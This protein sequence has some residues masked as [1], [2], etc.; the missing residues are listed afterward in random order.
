MGI[1]ICLLVTAGC[2]SESKSTVEV[3]EISK[4]RV[5]IFSYQTNGEQMVLEGNL[6]IDG[7]EFPVELYYDS[8]QALLVRNPGDTEQCLAFGP[9]KPLF[10]I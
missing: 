4:N 10:G 6:M 1:A 7:K 5:H 2:A 8:E 9:N 3:E